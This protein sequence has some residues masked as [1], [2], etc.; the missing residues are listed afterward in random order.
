M[1]QGLSSCVR[2]GRSIQ[3]DRNRHGSAMYRE[4]HSFEC[5][6]NGRSV[7]SHLIDVQL[8]E[9]VGSLELPPDWLD[10]MAQLA[11]EQTNVIDISTLMEQRRR[12][13]RVYTRGQMSDAEYDAKLT[14]LDARI[15]T[16]QP[17]SLP[18]VE[19][20]AALLSDLP[21]FWQEATPGE[22][23][24][25]VTPFIE[26][27]YIDVEARRIA[28]ITPAPG[29]RSLLDGALRCTREAACLVVSHEQA[30]KGWRWWRRGRVELPVQRR[31]GLRYYRRVRRL[32]L[33]RWAVA[34]SASPDRADGLRRSVSASDRSTPAGW[35]CTTARR[36]EACGQ[37][38]YIKLCSESERSFAG[39]WLAASLAR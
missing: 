32:V 11:N 21:T 24:R 25:L 30:A 8:G 7:L 19:A 31:A 35:R 9:I 38:R 2:C 28:A 22:R 33:V 17:V 5:T 15:R 14:D 12:L 27:A 13:I 16:A 34:G 3:S 20:A 6:T 10:R 4:R 26:R 1:L 23:R 29:F 39:Y 36:G 18:G 37:R